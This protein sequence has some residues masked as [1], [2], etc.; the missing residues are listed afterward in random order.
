MISGTISEV[1]YLNAQR[2]HRAKVEKWYYLASGIAIAIGITTYFFHDPK[3]GLIVSCA[4]IGGILGELIMSSAYLPRKINHLY[5]QQ[6]DL[7]SAF[8]YKWDSDFIEAQGVSGQSKRK[9]EN[10]AKYREDKNLFLL[11]HADNI[12]EMFPKSWFESN[13]QVNE[14][15]K[16]ASRAG[17]A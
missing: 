2:L 11:Y 8:T 6:K 16:L 9:W 17:Q 14:F 13:N 3:I 10:Y 5:R 15:R 12:F 1:D 7:A 4:G